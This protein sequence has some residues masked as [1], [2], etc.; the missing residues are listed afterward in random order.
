MRRLMKKRSRL[1]SSISACL[2]LV[3]MFTST[4][5]GAELGTSDGYAADDC[6]DECHDDDCS[7]D[8]CL[9]TVNSVDTEICDI[10]DDAVATD[11]IN[12][13]KG[14]VYGT[15]GLVTVAKSKQS[16]KKKLLHQLP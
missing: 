9:D 12:S 7:C 13:A 16:T 14:N 1:I 11:T 3:L 8:D 15:A 6:Y 2:A 5:N 4:I 10:E